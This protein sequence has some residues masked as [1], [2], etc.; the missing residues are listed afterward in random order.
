V[1]GGAYVLVDF[2]QFTKV[3]GE[4]RVE[5]GVSIAD[6]FQGYPVMRKDVCGV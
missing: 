2:Q 5:A 3:G 1:I 4:H 6:D